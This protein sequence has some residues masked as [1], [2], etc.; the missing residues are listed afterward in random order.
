MVRE[1]PLT[2]GKVALV[3]DDDYNAVSQFKWRVVRSTVK[4]RVLFYA[5]RSLPKSE[6][7]HIQALHQFLVRTDHEVD[8][9]DGDGLNNQRSNIRPATAS[10]NQANSH[11]KKPGASSRFRGVTWVRS[12]NRWQ[13]VIQVN[14]KEFW[15]GRFHS[16]EDAA[17]A[18]D[19]AA[20]AYFGEFASPNF[21][22][23]S[24]QAA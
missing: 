18:Y 24:E 13:S 19:A 21:P 11:F 6:P 10:Q 17:R 20:I 23:E 16:E 3:D 14:N 22:L 8:H 12:R 7:K 4:N 1:I 5:V 9:K 15:I 2:Q